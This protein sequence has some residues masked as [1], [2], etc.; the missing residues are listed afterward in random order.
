MTPRVSVIVPV[1]NEAE[2]I[3]TCL[4]SILEQRLDAEIEVIVADG[5]SA[6]GTAEIARSLGATVVDN[7]ARTTPAALNAALAAARGEIVVRFDAHA[8]MPAGYLRACVD[9]VQE[10][11]DVAGVGGWSL[12][13]ARGP[14]GRALGAALASG[15]ATGNPRLWRTPREHHCRVELDTFSFGCWPAEELRAAGGWD[16]RFVRN[17]DFELNYRLRKRGGRIL[18]DPNIWFVYR[19][20]ESLAAIARQ[21]WDYGRFK[22]LLVADEPLALRPRQLAPI[23][24]LLTAATASLPVVLAP[25]ARRALGLYGLALGLVA[26]KG[27]GGVRTAPVLAT[28]HLAWGAG[29]VRGLLGELRRVQ[30]A[31]ER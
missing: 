21:Y 11:A 26:A 18:F 27:G 28:I 24:L 1:R 16:E 5:C 23:A 20:R 2:H 6:D 3:A 15:F 13:R 17:Q 31:A 25:A 9:A 7:P 8:E 22:A 29:L 30:R 12:V 19:P 10:E 14:W 4:R